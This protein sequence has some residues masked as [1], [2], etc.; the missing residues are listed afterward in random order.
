M[1]ARPL[2]V[3]LAR[4]M[5]AQIAETARRAVAA[6]PAVE[7]DP[8][9]CPACEAVCAWHLNRRLYPPGRENLGAPLGIDHRDNVEL[10]CPGCGRVHHSCG[11]GVYYRLRK[12]LP[13]IG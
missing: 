2:T 10:P 5:T 7:L 6:Q 9:T 4:I 3:P 1:D 8:V 11:S 13:A 12:G